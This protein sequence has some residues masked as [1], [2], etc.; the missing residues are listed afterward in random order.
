[1]TDELTLLSQELLQSAPSSVEMPA[2]TGKTHLLAASVA[3]AAVNGHRSLVL[4]H[5]N[6]GVEAIR[7]R[8]R[9]FGVSP[10]LYR[11]ETITSWAYLIANAYYTIADLKPTEIPDWSESDVY[12]NGAALVLKTWTLKRVLQNSFDYLLVDEYQD[13]T[14]IQHQLILV[15]AEAIP[16]TIVLG[17]RMQAIFGFRGNQS[18]DWEH[19][20]LH[21]F[22]KFVV[23]SKPYRWQG[24]NVKLGQWL[25]DI[26]PSLMDGNSF[27][28]SSFNI[29]GLHVYDSRRVSIG[30]IAFSFPDRSSRVVLLDKWAR[31]VARDASMLGGSYSVMEDINGNFMRSH[32][33]GTVPHDD[34]IA[35]PHSGD[36]LLA[37]WFAKFAKQCVIGLRGINGPIL[38]HLKT[39][40]TLSRL[41]RPDIQTVIEA[42]EGLRKTP[43][44][45]NLTNAAN[46]IQQN[47]NLHIYRWEA[48]NDTL[49][50]IKL[51]ESNKA[52]VIENFSLVREQLRKRGRQEHNRIASRTLLVK[53]LEYDHVI[54][55]DLSQMRDPKNLYVALSRARESVS[56]L[57]SNPNIQLRND[58]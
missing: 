2:G 22:P 52:S 51:S 32:L 24:H 7:K 37:F 21:C 47:R 39:N 12:I 49:K 16:K 53:G 31:N 19:D 41:Q 25:L 56:I 34:Q 27:N 42:L 57:C 13:C 1:M 6:A 36:P 50:A 3:T 44:F 46:I 33:N 14:I 4:T 17:D 26:R 35:I 48:W 23:E 11:V 20:V 15:M 58:D 29:P 18:V 10:T 55:A 30:D 8:L 9:K 43:T 45:L 5:T 28:F 38:N 54:I 40:K